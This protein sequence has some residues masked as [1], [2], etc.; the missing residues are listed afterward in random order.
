MNIL[1]ISP[2]FPPVNAADMQRVRISLPFY[3][4]FGYSPEIV[5][6]DP[7]FNDHNQDELLNK[8]LPNKLQIHWI[9]AF[10]KKWTTKVGLG[11]IAL[12]SL[13]F[14][15]KAV[16]SILKSR[17]IDLIYFST[18]QFPICILGSYWK[19]KFGIPYVIDMQDPWHSDFYLDKPKNERPKKFWFSYQLNKKL[20]PIAM[21]QVDGLISVSDAYLK[22]LEERY[23][24]T[25]LIPRAVITFGAFERDF[26]ISETRQLVDGYLKKD[27]INIVYIG[28]GGKD[29]LMSIKKILMA[30]K[31]GLRI[32]PTY[33]S[34]FHFSFIGTSYAPKGQGKET[35]KDLVEELGLK[36]FVSEVTDRIPFYDSINLLKASDILF[37]PG[38]IDEQ[39]TASKIYPYIMA[40]RPLISIFHE[41]SSAHS[42]LNNCSIGTNLTLQ[43]NEEEVVER[44]LHF[45][46]TYKTINVNYDKMY[47]EQFTARA[48]TRRQ[49]LLFDEVLAR[50]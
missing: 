11:S 40:K 24:Q 19:K 9:K 39:Y 48:M 29:M 18:T 12:R 28:R 43:M 46:K 44:V 36:A 42:I 6:V 2:C 31:M 3:K 47:F 15:K 33:F 49:C 4:E 5:A 16:D 37:I 32:D 34:E 38:S 35:T 30:F 27:K 10:P 13:F 23:P 20:E 14:Y 45:F 1:I 21:K 7:L 8:S 17:N 50:R 41:K 22:S 26:E 25:K